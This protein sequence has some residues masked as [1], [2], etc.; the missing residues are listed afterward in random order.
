MSI[1]VTQTDKCVMVSPYN[2]ILGYEKG[3][4]KMT[5]TSSNL[6]SIFKQQKVRDE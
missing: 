6:D 2:L 3:K 5:I 4:P 1:Y